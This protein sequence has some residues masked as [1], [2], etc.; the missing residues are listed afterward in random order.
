MAKTTWADKYDAV[1]EADFSSSGYNDSMDGIQTE[2]DAR[3]NLP[4]YAGVTSGLAA[5]ISSTSIAVAS[6][7]GYGAGKKYVGSASLAFSGSDAA[8]TWYI[9]WDS[10]AEALAKASSL[11]DTTEDILLCSVV[12]NGSTTLSALV[13]LRLWGIRPALLV[14]MWFKTGTVTAA[15]FFKGIVPHNCF[16]EY[17]KVVMSSTGSNG[18]TVVDVSIGDSGSAATTIFTTQADRPSCTGSV[19]AHTVVSSGIP[20]PAQRKVTTGQHIQIDVDSAGTGAQDLGV[21][22]YGRLY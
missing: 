11:P 16:V 9:Y 22:V 5:S 7:V 12:W 4:P 20:D 17:V 2:F 6:G 8:Q 15:T 13:D 3:T 19:A 1:S 21:C 10:S 14:A 18:A